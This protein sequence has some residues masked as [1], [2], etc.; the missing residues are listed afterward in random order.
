MHSGFDKDITVADLIK[1]QRS[2]ALAESTVE[3]VVGSL[4]VARTLDKRL[5]QL[6]DRQVGQLM[7]DFVGDRATIFEP[8]MAIRAATQK[9]EEESY[10]LKL[11][12]KDK[13]LADMKK[14][15]EELR[16]KSEQGS[17]QLQGEVQ[18]LELEA[19]LKAAFPGVRVEFRHCSEVGGED[20]TV[21]G[22]Q[23]CDEETRLRQCDN[24]P[25]LKAPSLEL[26]IQIVPRE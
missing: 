11:A 18:E 21:A 19:M 24:I 9:E 7:F 3:R 14:Q 15:V 1:I 4:W 8:E 13:L 2:L 17:Q 6:T 25:R 10:L 22:L 20:F 23:R 26:N 5:A 12:E 16:R